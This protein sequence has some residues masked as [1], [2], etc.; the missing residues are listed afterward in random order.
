MMTLLCYL[1][2]FLQQSFSLFS[3]SLS[4]SFTGSSVLGSSSFRFFLQ[5]LFTLSISLSLD[6]VF[7]Q[8]S[9][10]LESVT[11][12]RLVQRVVQ[13]SVDLTSISV[14]VS[15]THLDVYKRQPVNPYEQ[16]NPYSYS[17]TI[18]HHNIPNAV[19]TPVSSG[20]APTTSRGASQLQPNGMPLLKTPMTS[21]PHA[22]SIF[23]VAKEV[24]NQQKKLIDELYQKQNHNQY[25]NQH[26]EQHQ[27]QQLNQAHHQNQSY[28]PHLM[29]QQHQPYDSFRRTRTLPPASQ[30]SSN[31]PT[32]LTQE[33]VSH[34]QQS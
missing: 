15:Y 10:V 28:I 4:S 11:L 5:S 26:Q 34:S 12:S 13:V 17:H 25:Q 1:S 22:Q 32:V 7:N 33:T 6:D 31:Q 16:Y 3:D 2:I 23:Q 21:T 19:R 30:L 18:Q 14:P 8:S 27:H 20:A 9:L 24:E 29:I